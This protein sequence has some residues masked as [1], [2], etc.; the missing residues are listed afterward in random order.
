M[1]VGGLLLAAELA[2]IGLVF[3]HGIDFYC[4]DNWPRLACRSASLSL[5]AIYC[6]AGALTLFFALRRSALA[7]LLSDAGHS[8]QPLM[9]NVFGCALAMVPVLFLAEGSGARWLIPSFL[10]WGTG[11][12]LM[13]GG[14]FSYLA[15]LWRWKA[16]L[17]TYGTTLAPLIAVAAATPW[18]SQLIQPLWNLEHIQ[19]FTFSSVA[20]LVEAFGYAVE[21][22]PESKMIGSGDF[23]ISVA[24]VCSGIEG[25]MLVTIFVSLYLW[26]FRSELRFPLAFILYPLGLAA[27]V[28]F[29][30][31]RITALMIIGIEGNPELAVGGFHS[32]AG[33]LMFTIVALGVIALARAVPALRKPEVGTVGAAVSQAPFWSDP[34]VARILP[35]AVFMLTALL[36]ST[37]SQTPA[38]HYP[39]RMLIVAAVVLPFLPVYRAFDWRLDPVALA[40]GAVIG[41]YWVLIPV[42]PAEVAPYGTLTGGFLVL[43]FLLRGFGTIVLVPLVE[44]LFFR[45]YLETRLRLRPGL[46]WS[47][48]A[49]LV[50]AGIFAALHARWA[51]AFVAGL[52]FSYVARRRGRIGDAIL[53]HAVANAIVFA[54]A[55]ATGN[56][57]MI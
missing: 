1:I 10:F 33:W 51:E 27:S 15:P 43:W 48:V 17:G 9:A 57:A 5:V 24:P 3:K 39:L 20:W 6:V 18:L 42:A 4:L 32:H 35:F 45:D 47:L 56:L 44:E 38:M 53:A 8:F 7:E 34:T 54:V 14:L 46:I 13:L 29:N 23:I 52:I 37:L 19:D 28:A 40:G 55:A 31:V 49:A 36:A 41:L 16:F 21:I 11:M 30:V 26:L 12:A 22:T 2:A 25:M 50:T